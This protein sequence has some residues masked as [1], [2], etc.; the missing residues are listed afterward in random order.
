MLKDIRE[1]HDLVEQECQI[2]WFHV[3]PTY[4]VVVGVALA[5]GDRD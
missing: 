1:F 5:V 2:A 4:D 3:V